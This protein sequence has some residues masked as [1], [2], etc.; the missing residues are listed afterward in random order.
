MYV[1]NLRQYSYSYH[2][3][4]PRTFNVNETTYFIAADLTGIDYFLKEYIRLCT[5]DTKKWDIVENK[6]LV[7]IYNTAAIQAG[8]CLCD[9]LMNHNS[10]DFM[11]AD[12]H[13]FADEN[14]YPVVKVMEQAEDTYNDSWLVSKGLK[15]DTYICNSLKENTERV[16]KSLKEMYQWTF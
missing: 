3:E 4:D 16:F 11:A 2:H 6:V 15:D 14:S 10:D 1:I 5:Q 13:I 8:L 9:P 12:G 7:R